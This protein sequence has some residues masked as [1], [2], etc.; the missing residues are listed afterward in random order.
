MKKGK[1]DDIFIILNNIVS[2]YFK[3]GLIFDM[4]ED[5]PTPAGPTA[6]ES[7][8][9]M[10]GTVEKI[11]N[12]YAR[13]RQLPE[14]DFRGISVSQIRVL[15]CIIGAPEGHLKLK[16]IAAELGITAGAASQAVEG[17]VKVGLLDR[18]PDENDRRSVSITL[19]RRGR[20]LHQETNDFFSGFMQQL[21]KDVTPEEQVVFHVVLNK[22]AAALQQQKTAREN[23]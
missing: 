13:S 4:S 20:E 9:L 15:T 14:K 21:L 18:S 8:T 6:L 11:R 17:L 1:K 5:V 22:V 10:S 7:W 19:S 2:K 23:L 3:Y 16:E 12:Y